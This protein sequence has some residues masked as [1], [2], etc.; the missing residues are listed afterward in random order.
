MLQFISQYADTAIFAIIAGVVGIIGNRV[1]AFLKYKHLDGYVS[2]AVKYAEQYLGTSAGQE[3]YK[4]VVELVAK[5]AQHIGLKSLTGDKLSAYIEAA[6]HDLKVD[7]GAL[8]STA[9]EDTPVDES[10]DE[11][12]QPVEQAVQAAE[13]VVAS[14]TQKVGDLTI[15]E[16]K[17][18]LFPSE[19]KS[20]VVSGT[21][22]VQSP[23]TK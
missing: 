20:A 1:S 12:V 14:E 11:A 18:L 8:A 5:E 21:N 17:K 3:K 23:V 13:Q 2:K 4:F 19:S 10:K 6:V 9:A 15:D 7:Q 16:L 22:A